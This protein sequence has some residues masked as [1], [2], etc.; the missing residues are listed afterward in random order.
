MWMDG[1]MNRQAD[2]QTDRQTDRRAQMT[3]LTDDFRNF[4]KAA[5][6]NDGKEESQRDATLTVY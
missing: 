1:E 5:R 2:R 3:K 4:A 6:S